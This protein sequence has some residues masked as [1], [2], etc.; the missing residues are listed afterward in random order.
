MPELLPKNDFHRKIIHLDMDAFYASIEMRDDPS[1]VNKALIIGHDPRKHNGH[2]VVATANYIA[3]QYGVHS[4]MPTAKAMQLVPVD[5]VAFVKPN[6]NKYRAV[7]GQIHEL[8]HE[9]TDQVESVALDEAYLDVTKNKLGIDSAIELASH[10]QQKIYRETG[11]TSSFGVSYNK[12]LAKMA[13]EYAKPF[14]R[15]VILADD[16]LKF[17][18]EQKIEQFPGIGKKTQ[19]QLHDL[20]I[21]DGADLQKLPVRFLIGKF[22]KMGYAIALHAHGIDLNPVLSDRRRKSIGIERTFENNIHS[23]DQAL[24]IIRKFSH[25]LSQKLKNKKVSA[26]VVVLKIRSNSFETITKRQKLDQPTNQALEIFLAGKELYSQVPNF[27]E[28]GIRLLGLTATNLESK[29][30]EEVPLELFTDSNILS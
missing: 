9:L 15:T 12:F 22:K 11:L 18:A 8:M 4:A 17:L 23:Q 3:R 27:L 1:L 13:S 25:E 21:Y 28:D 7:S 30:Y 19:K 16:A 24:T 5:R 29:N 10:L 6:F 20:G 26:N 2:G 14:G